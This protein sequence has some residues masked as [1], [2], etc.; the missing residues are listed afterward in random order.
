V[1]FDK[2]CFVSYYA[3]FGTSRL[4]RN[5]PGVQSIEKR[6]AMLGL[7]CYA[8]TLLA[9]TAIALPQRNDGLLA[10]GEAFYHGDKV[11]I[12]IPLHCALDADID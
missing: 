8:L 1:L 2:Y 5:I 6:I 4:Q 3:T 9:T 11:R 10:C 7:C 12:C